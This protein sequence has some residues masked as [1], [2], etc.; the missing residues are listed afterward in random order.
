MKIENIKKA[1][2]LIE[3]RDVWKDILEKNTMWKSGHFE[4]V[5]D[6]GN[7]PDRIRFP[8]SPEIKKK[9]MNMIPEEVKNIE[10]QLKEL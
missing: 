8:Y 4:F 9:I 1:Q 7:N 2:T 5:E 10:E 3:I 6:Y